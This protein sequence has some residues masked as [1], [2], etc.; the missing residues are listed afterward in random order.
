M[1]SKVRCNLTA[2][3]VM[4]AAALFIALGGTSYAVGINTIG[5]K[6]IKNG[7]IKS[8]DIGNNKVVGKDIKNGSLTSGDIGNGK[9]A[10]RDLKK[11]TLTASAFAGGVLP[12]GPKGDTG[13]RGS[14]GANAK[15][16]S[17]VQQVCNVDGC[18]SPTAIATCAPGERVVGGGAYSVSDDWVVQ[19][20]PNGP[21]GAPNQWWAQTKDPTG[22][23]TG[24]NVTA[25]AL[26]A[27]P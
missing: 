10:G 2:A 8:V 9:L 18:L 22:G 1:L 19:S 6:Q 3:N 13:V 4:S 26:C 5:S 23:D 25:I 12:K 27:T 20:Y 21:A 16:K 7:S 15:T 11:G 24:A 17:S 14:S